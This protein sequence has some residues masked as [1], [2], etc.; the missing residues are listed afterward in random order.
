MGPAPAPSVGKRSGKAFNLAILA[1]PLTFQFVNATLSERST[2]P[3][4][5][6][7]ARFIWGPDC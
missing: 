3:R 6:S 4:D 2:T 5:G 7:V 1:D